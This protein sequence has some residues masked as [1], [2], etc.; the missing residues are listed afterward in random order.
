[1]NTAVLLPAAFPDL[2]H[3]SLLKF[4]DTSFYYTD[5]RFSRKSLVHRGC[6]RTRDGLSWL[7]LPVHP[8]D[9]KNKLLDVR[10]DPSIDWVSKFMLLLKH[11]YQNST[12]FH[13]YGDELEADFTQAAQYE[14]LLDAVTFLQ[15]R[16]FRYLEWDNIPK[17]I[18]TESELDLMLKHH[19]P[20]VVYTEPGSRYYRKRIPN[21]VEADIVL[22]EYTHYYSPFLSGCC[23]LDL[24]FHHGPESYKI[25]DTLNAP[26]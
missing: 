25:L 22:P 3:L 18:K 11:S 24:L 20:A 10:I 4:A 6:I 7:T 19:I 5:E 17:N 2:T 1:M 23:V 14:L 8:S 16:F 21:Q 26:A 9:K 15:S 12:Y 13:F